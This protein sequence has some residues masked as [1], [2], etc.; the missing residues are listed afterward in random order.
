MTLKERGFN[1]SKSTE[2]SQLEA[3]NR[4]LVRKAAAEGFVL[5]KNEK[6]TL[7]LQKGAKIALYGS[8]ARHTIKGGT[9]SGDVAERMSVTIYDGLKNNEM[10]I[11]S[12]GW[13]DSYDKIF[14]NARIAWRDEINAKMPKYNGNFFW[15]YTQTQFV[16]PQGDLL[17]I[18][19]A[20][21]DGADTAIVVLSRVAGENAD[22]HDIPGDYYVSDGEYQLVKEVCEAYE[23]VVLVINTGGLMDLAF[24][25]QFQTLDKYITVTR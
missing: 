9:G 21:N 8:G 10:I 18:E 19:K 25:E 1:G 16:M 22:R 11:T 12:E 17:D 6:D 14:Q 20:K 13:L 23:K 7:P 3:E 15:A 24:T 2:V 4:K 5:L